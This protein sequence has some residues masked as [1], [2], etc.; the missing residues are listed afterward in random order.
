MYKSY[1][2]LHTRIEIGPQI[3]NLSC[4]VAV[5]SGLQIDCKSVVV[6]QKENFVEIAQLALQLAV[7]PLDAQEL[8][9]VGA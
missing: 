1:T 8:R 9:G 7:C 4:G 2:T 3:Q 5:H 6:C